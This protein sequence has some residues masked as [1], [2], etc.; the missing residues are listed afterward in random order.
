MKFAT[1]PLSLLALVLALPSTP[2]LASEAIPFRFLLQAITVEET[3]SVARLQVLR[4]DDA[5]H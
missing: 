1:V 3:D 4:A 2:V 5:G